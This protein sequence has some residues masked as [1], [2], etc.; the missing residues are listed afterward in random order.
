MGQTLK[1]KNSGEAQIV[2][3]GDGFPFIAVSGSSKD[4]VAVLTG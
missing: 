3:C 4:D 1:V 2:I